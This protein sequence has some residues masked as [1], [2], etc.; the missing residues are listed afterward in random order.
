MQSTAI[1]QLFDLSPSLRPRTTLGTHRAAS[2]LRD[3]SFESEERRKGIE[4]LLDVFLLTLSAE[5]FMQ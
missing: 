5:E 1:Q 4:P 3:N 2:R